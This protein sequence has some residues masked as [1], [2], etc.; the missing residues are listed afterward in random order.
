LIHLLLIPA[1]YSFK[2]KYK[3][4]RSLLGLNAAGVCLIA[5]VS[6]LL[7]TG[8]AEKPERNSTSRVEIKPMPKAE[9]ELETDVSKE[10]PDEPEPEKKEDCVFNND[11]KGLTA[12]AIH[13]YDS[14]LSYQWDTSRNSAVIPLERKCH[15][16]Q[17]LALVS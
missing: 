11:I 13:R 15:P 7:F 2:D 9:Q 17:C 1:F 16:F 8:R 3:Q 10:T 4:K 14:A 6:Y 12:E 5:L